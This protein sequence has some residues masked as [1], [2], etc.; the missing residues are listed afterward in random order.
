ME[1]TT[2]HLNIPSWLSER[3]FLTIQQQDYIRALRNVI[4]KLVVDLE[5]CETFMM[6]W[7]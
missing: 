7:K 1:K 3:N 4:K 6:K 2:S 5:P